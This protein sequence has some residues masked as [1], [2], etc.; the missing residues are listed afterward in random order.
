MAKGK[1]IIAADS[2]ARAVRV[3]IELDTK[4]KPAENAGILAT[5]TNEIHDVL[6]K[7]FCAHQISVPTYKEAPI[8]RRLRVRSE[9]KKP[10]GR[11]PVYK[12][13]LR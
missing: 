5:V 2:A 6:R 4:G 13:P 3:T 11:I 9:D 8:P 7:H 12:R 10:D 1:S